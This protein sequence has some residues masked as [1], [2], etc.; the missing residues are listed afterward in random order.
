MI[1]KNTVIIT[2]IKTDTIVYVCIHHLVTYL[3]TKVSFFTI[4]YEYNVSFNFFERK[5]CNEYECTFN[6]R[7]VL[8]AHIYIYNKFRIH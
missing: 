6:S 2:A 3:D 7:N 1:G 5:Y 4:F 8:P